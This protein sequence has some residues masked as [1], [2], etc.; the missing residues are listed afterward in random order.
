VVNLRRI[1]DAFDAASL[2]EFDVDPDAELFDVSDIES[3]EMT[4]V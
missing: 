3:D 1:E 2:D 4:L